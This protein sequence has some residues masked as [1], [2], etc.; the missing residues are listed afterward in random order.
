MAEADVVDARLECALEKWGT[1]Q[2]L[3]L[4]MTSSTVNE[5]AGIIDADPVVPM[6]GPRLSG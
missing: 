5:S 1:Y 4:S 6:S 3:L 2:E